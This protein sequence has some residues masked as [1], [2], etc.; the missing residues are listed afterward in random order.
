MFSLILSWIMQPKNAIIAGISIAI[1]ALGIYVKVLH[2][3][4]EN[5]DEKITQLETLNSGLSLQ[6]NKQNLAIK[7]LNDEYNQ[8][9]IDFDKKYSD[10]E[11]NN[12][13][14]VKQ[15]EKQN[16]YKSP[17]GEIKDGNVITEKDATHAVLDDFLKNR[18][19][20]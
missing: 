10:L 20:K 8:S 15:I 12:E 5:R 13:S 1:L 2:V 14:K 18:G 19:K 7:Q 11:K 4:I 9:K 3:K 16:N 17:I 6:L